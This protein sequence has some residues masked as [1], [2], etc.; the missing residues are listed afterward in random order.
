VRKNGENL[1]KNGRKRTENDSTAQK[2]NTKKEWLEKKIKIINNVSKPQIIKKP[3]QK[4]HSK[5]S[6]TPQNLKKI[7]QTPS[8]RSKNPS[9]TPKNL[10]KPEKNTEM[11][12]KMREFRPHTHE[13][14]AA[15]RAPAS[16]SERVAESES[17]GHFRQ[18]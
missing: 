7:P 8:K 6:K 18:F 12:A 1:R 17:W 2:K 3:N 16:G 5:T 14:G 15:A 4:K 11:T 9:K 10:K 13:S